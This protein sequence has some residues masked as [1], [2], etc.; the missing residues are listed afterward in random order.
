MSSLPL[1]AKNPHSDYFF[2]VGTSN[3]S[4]LQLSKKLRSLNV[5]NN[6]FFLSLYDKE[7]A[8]FNPH[9]EN[10]PEEIKARI[11]V[12]AARNPWYFYREVVKVSVP[13]GRISFRLHVGNLAL[14]WCMMNNINHYTI[15]PRQ[16]YKTVSTIVGCA[17]IYTLGTSNSHMF[18]FNKSLPDSINNLK[19]L[20]DV[21]D[22]LPKWLMKDVLT[23][24]KDDTNNQI[25]IES[26]YRKNRIDAKAP[27]SSLEHADRQGRG[28]TVPIRYWDELAFMPYAETTWMASAPAGSQADISAEEQGVPYGTYITTTPNNLDSESGS[29]AHELM[30]DSIEMQYGFYDMEPHIVKQRA[31]AKSG[32]ILIQY[33]Y[34]TLGRDEAW[35]RAQK[36]NLRND[37]VKVKREILLQWPMSD[38]SS[39]FTEEELDKLTELKKPLMGSIPIKGRNIEVGLTFDYSKF[40]VSDYPYIIG[41][42]PASGVGRDSSAF[43]LT[44]PYNEMCLGS[45]ESKTADDKA[46][47]EILHYLMEVVFPKSVFVPELNHYLGGI[48][49]RSL[50]RAG[51]ENRIFYTIK[52]KDLPVGNPN[53]AVP[54]RRIIKRTKNQ[55]NTK[56]YGITLNQKTREE[57]IRHLLQIVEQSPE[58]VAH[59]PLQ[60]Q[61]RTLYRKNGRIEHRPGKHD[62]IVFAY[63]MTIMAIRNDQNILRR[64]VR[65]QGGRDQMVRQSELVAKANFHDNKEI[66]YNQAYKTLP[67]G[68]ST[69][70]Y[71]STL[72]FSQKIARLNN[73]NI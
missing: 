22:G 2:H 40:I 48:C 6:K 30:E 32:F 21:C 41:M 55:L 59:G 28:A 29:F 33:D 50:S 47:L 15:L 65:L 51:F 44:D 52:Q 64:L 8:N 42:D 63:L 71:K 9:D 36:Q 61:I 10:L 46:I 72:S 70:N 27:G 54:K 12:E 5:E 26:G 19:R 25:Y 24:T 18:F 4:F 1:V 56:N 43:A 31:N 53:T 57:A 62:D 39:I 45:L 3:L 34:K 67:D 16:N 66:D 73:I 60:E 38:N 17:W 69:E 58:K 7:L 35:F 37:L 14:L 13:G 49:V 20:K 23:N 11:V 68:S